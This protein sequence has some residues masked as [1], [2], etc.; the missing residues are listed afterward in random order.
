MNYKKWV[1]VLIANLLT[2]ALLGFLMRYKIAFSFP[3]FEQ[4]HLQ[5]AHSHFAFAAWISQ[6]LY[7]MLI[8]FLDQNVKI[9]WKRYNRLLIANIVFSIGMM[10]AFILYGYHIS[11]NTFSFLIVITSIVFT[12]FFIK[13]ALTFKEHA[14]VKY[15]FYSALFFNFIS[16]FGTFYLAYLMISKSYQQDVH[17]ASVYFYLHFQY[18]GWF[19]FTCFGLMFYQLLKYMPIN[20]LKTIFWVFFLS[21]FPSYFLSILWLKIPS[22]LYVI[23][24]LAS[25]LQLVTWC[26]LLMQVSRHKNKLVISTDKY[27]ARIVWVIL[28]AFTLKLILQLVSTVPFISHIAYSLRSIVIAYLHLV[29]LVIISMFILHYLFRYILLNSLSKY[30]YYFMIIIVIN[31][32]L[33]GIQGFAGMFTIS[34]LYIHYYLFIIS[35]FVVLSVISIFRHIQSL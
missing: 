15:W 25:V 9:N 2:V 26:Y 24:I 14:F 3:F 4:K 13:D 31:E 28:F 12:Y 8:Y 30:I 27:F 11:S 22:S 29:L 16:N 10:I 6:A 17:L 5:H 23:V 19:I 35:F 7:L 33:L 20:N 34:I 18:N 32:V 21:T 1:L